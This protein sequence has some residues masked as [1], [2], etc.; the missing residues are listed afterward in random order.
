M[1]LVAS[2]SNDLVASTPSMTSQHVAGRVYGKKSARSQLKDLRAIMPLPTCLQALDI[3]LA[4]VLN[5]WISATFPVPLGAVSASRKG[6]QVLDIT[7][8]CQLLV[9]RALDSRSAGAC[10]QSDIMSFYD[11]MPTLKIM[12][13]CV[14][15]GLSHTIA[16]AVVRHQ[17]LPAVSL[18]AGSARASIPHRTSGG[19]IGSRVAGAVGRVPVGHFIQEAFYLDCLGVSGRR[20]HP[21][22]KSLC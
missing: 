22:G 21:N 5:Q 16:A 12:R 19:I 11:C 18:Q 4:D 9:E 1:E 7:H 15:H 17:F 8:G 20:H 14:A 6:Y 2:Y 13:F 3:L 10:A